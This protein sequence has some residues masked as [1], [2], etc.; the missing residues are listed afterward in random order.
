MGI[1]WLHV[2]LSSG[3]SKEKNVNRICNY[4]F[5][6]GELVLVLNKWI[7]PKIGH[8]YKPCYLRPMVVVHKLRNGAY[9]LAKINSDGDQRKFDHETRVITNKSKII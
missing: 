7:E 1:S 2:T 6:S 9:T 4:D 8:K 5:K 3:T